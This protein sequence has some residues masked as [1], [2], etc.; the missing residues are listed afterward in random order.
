LRD[1]ELVS[2]SISRTNRLSYTK[3]GNSYGEDNVLKVLDCDQRDA[4]VRVVI[5]FLHFGSC[6]E[7]AVERGPGEGM[8]RTAA[9]AGRGKLSPIE[10]H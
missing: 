6:A 10:C 7:S 8:V 1:H 5:G 3:K 4:D 2:K 9:L